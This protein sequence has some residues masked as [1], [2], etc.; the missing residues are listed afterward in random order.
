MSKGAVMI[1][2]TVGSRDDA[3]DMAS[4]LIQG[5][6]AAC[7]QELEVGSHFN[8]NG[9]VRHE[10]E[11]L[12]L[13]KTASD[14]ADPAIRAIKEKHG[15]DTPEILVFPVIGGSN[16]YLRWIDDETRRESE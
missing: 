16:A 6:W 3:R 10:P 11:F 4:Y 13:I 8:W 7:V 12:L 1:M 14:C 2:T 5:R 9:E 15:Y